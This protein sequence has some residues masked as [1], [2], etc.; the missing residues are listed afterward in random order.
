MAAMSK[1][2]SLALLAVVLTACGGW[3]EPASSFDAEVQALV[4]AWGGDEAEYRRIF[5]VADC[6]QLD[7]MMQ[8]A[9][10]AIDAEPFDSPAQKARIGYANAIMVHRASIGC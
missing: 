6:G 4:Q 7:T 5:A 2:L 10:K 8:A 9:A 1:L 3:A